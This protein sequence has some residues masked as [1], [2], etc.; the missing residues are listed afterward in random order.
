MLLVS[1]QL[2]TIFGSRLA[3]SFTEKFHLLEEVGS[4][5]LAGSKRKLSNDS[6]M[7]IPDPIESYSMRNKGKRLKLLDT[8]IRVTF[9]GNICLSI[10]EN[11]FIKHYEFSMKSANIA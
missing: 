3:G 9:A 6:N 2:E 1:N 5:P 8:P 10:D 11:M 7:T 4:L